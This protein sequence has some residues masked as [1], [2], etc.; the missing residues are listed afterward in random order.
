MDAGEIITRGEAEQR[1]EFW[2][3]G[4]LEE[5]SCS[6]VCELEF[7]FGMGG[8]HCGGIWSKSDNELH[9]RYRNLI[10]D[11]NGLCG[12]RLIAVIMEYHEDLLADD[13]KLTCKTMS[14]GS[15]VCAG[16]AGFSNQELLILF[17]EVLDGR[18][19]AG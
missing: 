10:D 1:I 17:D 11:I 6:S 14:A 2:Q 16:L 13:E 5:Y 3:C 8:P 4:L 12:N 19:I 9:E 15:P 7:R 18:K